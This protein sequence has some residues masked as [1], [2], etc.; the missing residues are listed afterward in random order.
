[1]VRDKP[2]SDN[3]GTICTPLEL[4]ALDGKKR[5]INC[6]NVKGAFRLVQSIPSIPSLSESYFPECEKTFL[7]KKFLSAGKV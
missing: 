6:V 1:R 5:R 4:I 2:L 3:W 7:K